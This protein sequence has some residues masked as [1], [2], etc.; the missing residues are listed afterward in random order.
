VGK[1][2]SEEGKKRLVDGAKKSGELSKLRSMEVRRKYYDNPKN[3]KYC[4]EIIEYDKRYN[5]FCNSS[6]SASY[7]NVGKVKNGKKI[8]YKKCLFCHGNF[9]PHFSSLGKY[10]NNKCQK[11]FE[12]KKYIEEIEET[13]NGN[14]RGQKTLPNFLKSY[15]KDKLGCKCDICDGK[16]WMGQTIP[17]VLD[18]IDGNPENDMLY[19][20]RLVCGNCD[21]Q[22]PTYKSKNKGN[23]RH[24]RRQRYKEGKSC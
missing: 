3:C 2:F 9:K 12:R 16:E 20:L 4:N 8:E 1:D 5:K 23:G 21:M 11:D 7:N 15:L 22:L 18:H 14:P 10:C 13:Q 24:W 6:C 17:L 19:N